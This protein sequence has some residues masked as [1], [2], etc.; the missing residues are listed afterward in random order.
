MKLPKTV[1][2][3]G[4]TYEVKTDK[5]SCDGSG[6]TT[7]PHIIVG[8]ESKN[9]ER[10][11]EIFLHEVMEVAACER[12]YRYGSGL[13]SG[14]MFVMN[15]KEFDNYARDVATAIRPMLKE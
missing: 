8:T 7:N 10:Y 5:T 15:H 13:S 3:C 11:W 1:E 14:S 12:S 2:I 9:K 4:M 6:S